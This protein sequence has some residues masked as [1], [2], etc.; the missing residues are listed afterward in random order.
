M[1][2]TPNE[3]V[4]PQPDDAPAARDPEALE[5]PDPKDAGATGWHALSPPGKPDGEVDTR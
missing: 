4:D 3:A 2:E 1:S 5:P